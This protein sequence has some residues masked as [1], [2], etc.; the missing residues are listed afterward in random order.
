LRLFTSVDETAAKSAASAYLSAYRT[1]R[2]DLPD[3]CK[4]ASYVTAI[5]QSYPFHPELFN[6]LTK[7][8]ASISLTQGTSAGIHRSELNLSLFTPKLELGYVDTV[9]GKLQ[10]VAWYLD[11][12]PITTI[13][14]FREEP[15]INKIITQE[16]E[17]IGRTTAKDD[18]RDR[19]D[20]IF[21]KRAFNLVSAPESP[22]D[23]DDTPDNVVLCLIDF[24]DIP[25]TEGNSPAPALV[26]RIFNNT[27]SS[28]TFRK[29]RNRILFLVPDKQQLE[30][31]ITYG[32]LRQRISTRI[33]SD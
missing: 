26:D 4:D 19:R 18:L 10:S 25:I 23:V 28:G 21:A 29:Y 12:D 6:L 1:T 27:G 22:A 14:R 31:A 9:L 11:S 5:E 32:R 7:K 3:A 20:S 15:S 17:Q 13:S 24:D 8:I 33:S 16:R 2:S 30:L